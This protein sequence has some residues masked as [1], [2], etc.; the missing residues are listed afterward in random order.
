MRAKKNNLSINS[1]L[2]ETVIK[3]TKDAIVITDKDQKIIYINDAFARMTGYDFEEIKGLNPRFLQ[4]SK[5]NETDVKR[6]R[7]ALQKNLPIE[8]DLIN[9]KKEG[10]AFWVNI[11][12]TPIFDVNNQLEGF[13]SVERDI[14]EI[15]QKEIQKELTRKIGKFFGSEE[16]LFKSI[17]NSLEIIIEQDELDLAEVWL[18]NHDKS[19]IQQIAQKVSFSKLNKFVEASKEQNVF[20]DN[21]GLPGI[22]WHKKQAVIIEDVSKDSCF[23]RKKEALACGL[24]TLIGIPLTYNEKIIGVL[25]VASTKPY[26]RIKGVDT[27]NGEAF[28]AFFGSEITRKKQEEELYLF[29]DYSPDILGLLGREA[30]L[31]KVNPSFYNVLGHQKESFLKKSLFEFIHPEDKQ[32]TIV[33]FEEAHAGKKTNPIEVRMKKKSG[34]WLWI[35]WSFSMPFSNEDIVFAYGKDTTEARKTKELLDRASSYAKFGGWEIDFENKKV[36]WSEAV[37]EIFEVSSNHLKVD[38]NELISFFSEGEHRERI[39][40]LL[41]LAKEKGLSLDEQLKIETQKGNER[42]VRL[43]GTSVFE[44]GKVKKLVGSI[45]DVDV[46][47]KAELKLSEKSKFLEAISTINQTLLDFEDWE[48][49]LDVCLSVMGH[50]VNADRS[51]YFEYKEEGEKAFVSQ[52]VEWCAPGVFSQIE[53]EKLQQIPAHKL[54]KFIEVLKTNKLYL[55]YLDELVDEYLI[56]IFNN[57]NI[58]SLL[59]LPIFANNEFKG[60]VGFDDCV[61]NRFW[62]M[63]ESAFLFTAVQNIS[64]ARENQQV[65]RRL[66]ESLIAKDTILESIGDGFFT[67]DY[68]FVVSYWNKSA[69]EITG[70]QSSDVVGKNLFNVFPE[71][72]NDFKMSYKLAI[73]TKKDVHFEAFF[74]PMKVWLEV[75][76]YPTQNKILTVYFKDITQRKKDLEEIKQTNLRFERVSE[77]TNDAIWDWDLKTD[78]LYWGKGFSR[79]FGIN[80]QETPPTLEKWTSHIH[81]DDLK[82]VIKEIE[83]VL[84]KNKQDKFKTEYLFRKADGS[85]AN[86]KDRGAVV[87]NTEGKPVRIVGAITDITIQR[88]HEESLLKL[89]QELESRAK[90]LAESN[91]E[92][93]QFAYVASHDLQEPLRMITSFLTQLEKK[94]K[95]QLDDKAHQYI[96]YAVDGSNRM[97]QIIL[98]LLE[99]SR[100]GRGVDKDKEEQKVDLNE[101]VKEVLELQRK[102]IAENKATIKTDELPVIKTFRSPVFQIFN[103]L[104]SNALKYSDSERDV[105]VKISSEEHKNEWVFSVADNGIGIEKEYYDKIFQIFQRLHPKQAYSG[106]GLGLAIVKK[107]IQNLNGEIWLESELNKGSTFYFTIKKTEKTG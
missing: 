33:C 69:S 35:T 65:R 51:Y 42:W 1:D 63:D 57:G 20:K 62:K 12:I 14:T 44:E 28:G 73:E 107:L 2:L 68:N 72:K 25:L 101:V 76:V 91:E 24:T 3:H 89:N 10:E 74:T 46:L 59:L 43:I 61:K 45:Q 60:F 106:S 49:A 105:K 19:L 58:K 18:L 95:D 99:Y 48:D 6:I 39:I 98:D 52:K 38:V 67:M 4:G 47:K 83:Q 66:E 55:V 79:L 80:L 86:V 34:D 5:T 27:I 85:Y 7:K 11:S 71:E 15:K 64:I 32:K 21:E 96:H 93:E 75:S 16:S 22:V 50:V 94:Y 81:K 40:K 102:K 78:E 97:R 8:V 100:V 70:V 92:L 103:N 9:Y 37:K 30:V 41:V 90:A 84:A 53:D 26:S 87:R 56:E 13:I 29:F 88:E 31:N 17:Y 23:I 104:I 36:F 82:R 54:S 77:A